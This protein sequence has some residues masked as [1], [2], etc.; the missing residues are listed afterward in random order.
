MRFYV[1]TGSI[2]EGKFLGSGISHLFEHTLFEGTTTRTKTQIDDEVQ[3]IGGQ[4]NA[5]TSKDVTCYYITTASPYFERALASL[6]D[7]MQNANF[8]DKEVKT[9]IGVI[10]NEMNLGEDD[11]DRTLSQTFDE[12]AFIRHPTRFPIIG[13]RENFDRLTRDDILSYY[14]DHY[15]PGNVLLAVA[16]D[17]SSDQVFAMAKKYLAAWPRRNASDFSVPQEPRQNAP[18][19]A[20]VEKDVQLAYLS[21][22]WHT[23]PLQNPDLYALD[24]LSQILGGGESSRL[25]RALRERESLVSDISSYSSTPNYDAGV[26]G[27]TATLPAENLTKT[28]AAIFQQVENVIRQGV[29]SEELE[30][31]KRGIETAFV[32][33]SS[34]V[35]NQAEQIAYDELA[36]GDAAYSRRYVSRIKDVTT[37]QVQN[38]AR[39]YLRPEGTTT[40]IIRPRLAVATAITAAPVEAPSAPQMFRLANG[41]RVIV[42]REPGADTMALVAMGVGG[43]RLEPAG[44]AGLANLTTKLLTRGTP[45]RDAQSIANLVDTLG[46][47][48]S[49]Q[50]GYNSWGIS[51]RWLL[52][53]LAARS[54]LA[55]RSRHAARV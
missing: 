31:A 8:P 3:A 29:T 16:G 48:L 26:F 46:G 14:K 2:Y 20:V 4:S 50:S 30:R 28:E 32:F 6:S 9:Q 21:I 49:P 23:I 18:R 44:K 19:R 43:T 13:Y 54:G 51:S 37:E 12:T 11:P 41:M 1:K 40:A 35:E 33:S 39:K 15:Q 10:H 34:D 52:G 17:V 22:G 7:M 45:G 5:Y 25:V 38:V 27:V 53:R 42:R 47:D 55:Q 36:T 24:V